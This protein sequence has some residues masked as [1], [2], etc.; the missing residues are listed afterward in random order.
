LTRRN[1]LPAST[2]PAA[3]QRSAVCLSVPVLVMQHWLPVTLPVLWWLAIS[4][5]VGLTAKLDGK[6]PRWRELSP[7]RR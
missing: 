4:S 3:H 6:F 1:C 5:A 7:L 2:M